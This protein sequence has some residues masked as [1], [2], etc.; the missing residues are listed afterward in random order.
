MNLEKC[1]RYKNFLI[2]K[3]DKT[4]S[5]YNLMYYTE[6]ASNFKSVKEAMK[7]IDNLFQGDYSIIEELRNKRG[8]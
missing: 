7:Y 1:K 8:N 2:D 4:Y 5:I 3:K 6:I